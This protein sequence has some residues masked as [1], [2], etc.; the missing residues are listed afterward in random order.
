MSIWS[1]VFNVRFIRRTRT[2]K[3]SIKVCLFKLIYY[4]LISCKDL[5]NPN[6][7]GILSISALVWMYVWHKIISLALHLGLKMLNSNNNKILLNIH[8]L[9]QTHIWTGL[10]LTAHTWTDFGGNRHANIPAKDGRPHAHCRN[11]RLSETVCQTNKQMILRR[12]TYS[13]RHTGYI[14]LN[15]CWFSLDV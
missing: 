2:Y 12:Q 6:F 5:I 1:Q 14:Y 8:C 10:Y 3:Y 7:E 9:T 11:P 4:C 15:Y 13:P